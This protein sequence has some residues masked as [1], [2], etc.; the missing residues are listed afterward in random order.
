MPNVQRP[1]LYEFDSRPPRLMIP[2]A[3]STFALSLASPW[4][5]KTPSFVH[6]GKTENS[7]IRAQ[8]RTSLRR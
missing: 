8:K 2:V 3:R 5:L 1:M 7:V 4:S 6:C